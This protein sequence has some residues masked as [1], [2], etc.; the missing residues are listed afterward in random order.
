MTRLTRVY[1]SVMHKNPSGVLCSYEAS[2]LS[3]H[4]K[5]FSKSETELDETNKIHVLTE[6][7]IELQ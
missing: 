3:T 5:Y 6:Y 7:V 4:I 1:C 2:L